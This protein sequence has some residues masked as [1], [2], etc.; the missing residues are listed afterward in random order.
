MSE[1]A[2]HNGIITCKD[3]ISRRASSQTQILSIY[4]LHSRRILNRVPTSSPVISQ[5]IG[6]C[7]HWETFAG[8]SKQ[9]Q[10][11]LSAILPSGCMDTRVFGSAMVLDAVPN[12]SFCLGRAHGRDM[13]Q[14][15]EQSNGGTIPNP[16]NVQYHRVRRTCRG[17]VNDFQQIDRYCR[18]VQMRIMSTPYEQTQ[19]II[20]ILRQSNKF[21]A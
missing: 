21:P 13:S 3:F 20:T 4:A 8:F 9:Q 19:Y 5:C 6:S 16:M 12:K 17:P 11:S 10:V 18:R 7:C 15:R 1:Y 14:T 2:S